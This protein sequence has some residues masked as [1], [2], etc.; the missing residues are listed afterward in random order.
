[1]TQVTYLELKEEEPMSELRPRCHI[2][3]YLRD[4][5]KLFHKAVRCRDQRLGFVTS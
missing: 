3:M 4:W 1:M 2:T 5:N